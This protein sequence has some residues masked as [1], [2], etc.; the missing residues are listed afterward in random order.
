MVHRIKKFGKKIHFQTFKPSVIWAFA[1][2]SSTGNRAW[3][4][5]FGFR[6]R[7]S[8]G[9]SLKDKY[10]NDRRVWLQNGGKPASVKK[11]LKNYTCVISDMI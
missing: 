1:L 8:R 3:P 11:F 9:N 4:I 6:V 7:L 10:D 5:L 2:F